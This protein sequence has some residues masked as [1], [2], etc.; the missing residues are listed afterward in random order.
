MSLL[1]RNALR[2][3]RHARAYTSTPTPG[4]QGYLAERAALEH[5]AAE[6]SDLWRKISY[7][8]CFPAIAVCA[9]W[10][11]NAEAEHKQHLDHLRSQNEGNLP[12]VPAFEYLN[13]RT[14]PFPWGMNTLFFNPYTN[15]NM[16]E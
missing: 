1:A 2:T 7:F 3:A 10:V 13:K 16:E 12:E 5:H 9:A 8:V 6:T 11:Y 15:K 14:K 4:A